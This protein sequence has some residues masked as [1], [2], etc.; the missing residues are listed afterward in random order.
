[1]IHSELNPKRKINTKRFQQF[2][3]IDNHRSILHWKT[4]LFSLYQRSNDSS[5]SSSSLSN[6][7]YSI[8]WF[9]YSTDKSSSIFHSI[10]DKST[11]E[12]VVLISFE[13][14]FNQFI[15]LTLQRTNINN[16]SSFLNS[17]VKEEKKRK[18]SLSI[19]FYSFK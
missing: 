10:E 11:N 4:F 8:R 7:F 2:E 19:H 1:M 14:H 6:I 18:E 16:K 3:L 12:F 17:I 9:I 15:H 5:S 13:I